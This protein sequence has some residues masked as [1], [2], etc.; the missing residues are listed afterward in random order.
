MADCVLGTNTSS[1]SVAAIASACR[2]K[3]RVVGIHFFNPA[4]V[5]PLVEIVPALSTAPA[6]ARA[7]ADVVEPEPIATA[8]ALV[9][10]APLPSATLLACVA[11]LAGFHSWGFE[12]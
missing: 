7:A 10:S 11:W 5:M 4:P 3:E 6:Y 8:P 2:V 12:R 9:D 1:L